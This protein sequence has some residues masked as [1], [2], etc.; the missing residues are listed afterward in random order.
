MSQTLD[1]CVLLLGRGV[2]GLTEVGIVQEATGMEGHASLE[3]GSHG[4]Q[5]SWGITL[6]A[7]A[8]AAGARRA[9]AGVACSDSL[10]TLPSPHHL[11][12][13]M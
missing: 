11:A 13:L 5:P 9:G 6:G 8:K 4:L 7:G 3:T 1:D 2:Q 10:K 12:V